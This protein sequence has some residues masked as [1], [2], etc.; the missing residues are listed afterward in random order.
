MSLPA[1]TASFLDR[2][3]RS[4][5]ALAEWE[6]RAIAFGRQV[7]RLTP[8]AASTAFDHL[9]AGAFARRDDGARI[10][11]E[12]AM[13]ALLGHRWEP[14]HLARAR[15]AA[16][17]HGER[18][19]T[20]FLVLPLV[21]PVDEEELETPD[22]GGD[23]PLTLG[24]RR[25]LAIQP[26][27]AIL[28]RVL[29]DPHPMVAARLLGNPKLTEAEAVRIAARRLV[30]PALLAEVARHDRWRLRRRVAAALAHNPLT[31]HEFAVTLLPGLDARAVRDVF[32][33]VQ[34]SQA[35]RTAAAAL[36]ERAALF[37]QL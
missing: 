24:E 12:A 11:A 17:A 34:L 27:R 1:G 13:R 31:P 10:A 37:S 4:L 9:L 25:A 2:L 7:T 33:D 6:P 14:D 22:Y 29:V 15:Q 32:A 28:E 26:S 18:L 21:P 8:E 5:R 36:L 20:E 19:T 23:R 30:P 16:A 35:L 3:G